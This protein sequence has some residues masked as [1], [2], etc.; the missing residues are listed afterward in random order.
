MWGKPNSGPA[1]TEPSGRRGTRAVGTLLGVGGL[2]VLMLATTT[3]CGSA[4]VVGASAPQSGPVTQTS[5]APSPSASAPAG[6]T[7][8]KP[9]TSVN[10]GGPVSPPTTIS[11][12][13]TMP[14]NPGG[15]IQMPKAQLSTMPAGQLTPF[16]SVSQSA[17][18]RTLYMGLE[19]MGGACGQYDVVLKE[20]S[21]TVDLGLVHLPPGRVMCP[22]YEAHILVEAKLTAPLGSRDVVDLANGQPTTSVPRLG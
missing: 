7:P 20:S 19:S 10:P 4:K 9:P 16:D 15:V 8:G 3:A 17:D 18:G 22:M 6:N 1:D 5:G 13:P 11:T 2:G 12:H 14:I 21:A